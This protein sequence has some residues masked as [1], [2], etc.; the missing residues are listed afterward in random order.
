[1]SD[2]VVCGWYTWDYEHW[3]P[4]L[5]GDLEQLGIQHDFKITDKPK[6]ARWEHVTLRKAEQACLAV[7][8]HPDKTV[9]LL[10]VDCRVL[11]P[12]EP[13]GVRTIRTPWQW[14]SGAPL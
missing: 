12:L 1:M 7:Q 5:I 6:G 10:D 8:R 9:V 11:W 13:H 3:L 4:P 14:H 2:L